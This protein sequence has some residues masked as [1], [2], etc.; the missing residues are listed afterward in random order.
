M[1]LYLQEKARGRERAKRREENV[2]FAS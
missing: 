1:S 2:L